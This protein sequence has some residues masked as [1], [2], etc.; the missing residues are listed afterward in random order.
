MTRYDKLM[1]I[2][3][4]H[5]NDA[6]SLDEE[7]WELYDEVRMME[8]FLYHESLSPNIRQEICCPFIHCKWVQHFHII[9]TIHIEQYEGEEE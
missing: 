9:S 7:H 6:H 2:F 1:K 3:V 8:D 5:L 4:N